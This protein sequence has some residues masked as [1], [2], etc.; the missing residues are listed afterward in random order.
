MT[1]SL[2]FIK[3]NIDM[4]RTM[5]KEHDQQA[6]VKETPKKLAYD[7]SEEGDSGG[8]T[9][10]LSEQLSHESPG[11]SEAY[12]K[13]REKIKKVRTKSKER[14]PEY[15]ETS[16]D[17]ESKEDL[18]YSCEDLNT[19]YK[20]P[21][22]TPFTA[23]ITCFKYHQRAKVLRNIKVYEGNKDLDDHLS[24]F[25][26]AAEE[27]EWPMPV[28]EELS[29]KFLEEFLQQKR[30]AKDLTE[31]HSIKR[32]L[33]EGL[34]AFMDRFKSESSHIKGVPLVL[35]IS[36]FMHGHG[37][38]EL[39]KKLNDKIPKI[40]DEMFERIEE[41]VASGKLVHL[42]KDIRRGNQRSGGQGKGPA[43]VINM[44]ITG[45]SRKRPHEIGR[46]EL[47]DEI[48]FPPVPWNNLTDRSIILEGAIKGC[49]VR[50]IYV[51]GGS[52][53]EIMKEQNCAA[54]VRDSK[55]SLALQRNNG[56]VPGS[57]PKST[58]KYESGKMGFHT[59]VG[60]YC[61]THM[62]KELKNSTATLQRMME[63]VLADQKGQ[64]MEVYLEEIV[65]KSRSPEGRLARWAAE[66]RTY[67]VLYIPRKEAEGQ[68]V[69]KFPEQGKQMPRASG[70][71]DKG[72]SEKH[73]KEQVATPRVW[74]LNL[75]RDANN[76]GSSRG[77][78]LISSDEKR[79]SY[80]ICLNFY[81]FEES[82]HYEALLVG[83]VAY[84]GKGMQD[85]HVFVS[86]KELVDKVEGHK[87][88]K[89]METKKYMDEV[90]CNRS[91]PQV[92]NRTCNNQTRVPQPR[93]IGW[94]QDKTID[95]N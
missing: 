46:S 87:V 31:I 55:V 75:G 19:P 88:P 54:E 44:V 61:F 36:A 60:V 49:H 64:N 15:Q 35:R 93:G 85:L 28:F 65:V 86:S 32:R 80:A 11:T 82:M 74:R 69:R 4:L 90:G 59:E 48:A 63:R 62:P 22:P 12:G 24:I 56:V 83:L 77:M 53:L 30:Y 51:D 27:E 26:A 72:M 71:N 50:R 68:V 41:E 2:A 70:E 57:Y 6:K 78:I 13:S 16:S 81:A 1:P 67:D 42:V 17:S 84:A 58:A 39:A 14:R 21:K 94:Y 38:S 5:I 3:E 33:N 34:Q 91:I 9:K 40:V 95:G 43:K 73:Q 45:G 7:E 79:S 10:V 23:R 66:L 89:T 20:R 25:S 92:P 52:S 76:E 47:T 18:E 37:H 29:Q 8:R